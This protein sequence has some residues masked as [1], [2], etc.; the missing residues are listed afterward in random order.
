[1]D[2]VVIYIMEVDMEVVVMEEAGSMEM[3]VVTTEAVELKEVEA[4]EMGLV[5]MEVEL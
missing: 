5:K 2:V 1:M 3:E 4:V